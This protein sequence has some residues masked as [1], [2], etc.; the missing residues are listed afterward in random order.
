MTDFVVG[1]QPTKICS[2]HTSIDPTPKPEPVPEPKP[3]P[4]PD[5]TPAPLPYQTNKLIGT[6]YYEAITSPIDKIEHFLSAIQ[7]AGGHA[8][9]FFLTFTWDSGYPWQPWVKVGT[10]T[11]SKYPGVK[12]P[13]YD[14][15]QP[16]TVIWSKWQAIFKLCSKY[17]IVPIVRVMDYCSIK[18]NLYYKYY[19][20]R[21]SKQRL[22]VGSLTGG[23]WGEPIKKYKTQLLD[24]LI[25]NLRQAGCK[26]FY[27][28]PWNE[29]NVLETGGWT[30]KD[31]DRIIIQE[32]DWWLDQLRL[33]GVTKD[34]IIINTSRQYDILKQTG[35]LME[36]HGVNS[37]TTLI[38]DIAKFGTK[39]VW[40]NGDGPDTNATGRAGDKPTKREPSL[41]QAA[42]IGKIIKKYNLPGYCYFNR[43]TEAQT[44]FDITRAA[45]DVLKTIV[46]NVK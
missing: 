34:H 1:Q 27:I 9:E 44:P 40:Y 12:F 31:A 22:D 20:T 28:S 10:H 36:I 7:Q 21:A 25:S 4:K 33:Q 2:L 8:T 37:D 42:E 29:A 39:S 14:L 23:T 45:H 6:S 38:N 16:D 19:W 26:E 13:T 32:F 43:A 41:S 35:C 18:N 24:N 46:D 11:D 17:N 3:E 15:D 5:P 30:D